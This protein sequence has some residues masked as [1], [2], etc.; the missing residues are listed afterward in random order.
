M[1]L[2]TRYFDYVWTNWCDLVE[3]GCPDT[4]EF[5]RVDTTN[6]L[7][8]RQVQSL[9]NK[10]FDIP[11]LIVTK[12]SVCI[13]LTILNTWGEH[14]GSTTWIGILFCSKMN[15]LLTLILTN[16]CH[17]GIL[18]WFKAILGGLG[19]MYRINTAVSRRE[20]S[21]KALKLN[22]EYLWF[23]S[24]VTSNKIDFTADSIFSQ[25]DIINIKTHAH[26]N[27][28]TW[29]LHLSFTSFYYIYLY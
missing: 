25:F 20:N 18:F 12:A 11:N 28:K 19:L 5:N 14:F 8:D 26:W 27:E 1:I 3:G 2:L 4:E 10:K 22:P 9:V 17:F 21:L 23:R 13:F 7:W 29:L 15:L 24:V 6:I 16:G